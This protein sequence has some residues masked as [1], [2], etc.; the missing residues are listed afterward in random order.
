MALSGSV[1]TTAYDG[2]Y[3]QLD[4]TATQSIAANSSTIKW[5]LKA[6]TEG[7]WAERTLIVT[8]NG[9]DVYSKTA[10]VERWDGVVTSG[11]TTISH[12]SA[13]AANISISIKAAVYGSS[14]N[15]TGSSTVPLDTI[16]RKAELK[17][18]D[19]SWTDEENPKITYT[20]PAGTAVTSLQACI[21]WDK[22]TVVVAY[23]DIPKTGTLEYEFPLTPAEKTALQKGVNNG[24]TKRGVMFVIKTVIGSNEPEYSYNEASKSTLTI[25]DCAPT[26][27]PS[28]RDMN[29][30]TLKLTEGDKGDD[31]SSY[32]GQT[33][34]KGHS[35]VSASTGA[36]VP[37][38]GTIK[39]QAIVC[40]SDEFYVGS[41]EITN[42]TS[43]SFS[44]TVSDSRGQTVTTPRLLGFIN[45][46]NLSCSQS[47]SISIDD[48]AGETSAMANLTISGSYFDESFGAESNTLTLWYRYKKT[49]DPEWSTMEL[50][51]WRQVD[52]V[53][54]KSNGT[55]A[56]TIS[57]AGLSQT[58][59]YTF[60]CMA[61]DKLNNGADGAILTKEYKV[62]TQ[63]V[64]DWSETDFAFNV[65]VSFNGGISPTYFYE[66]HVNRPEGL[67][68]NDITTSG[69]YVCSQSAVA[70]KIENAP[71]NTAF[72]LEVLVNA[73]VTQRVTEYCESIPMKIFVRNY[74]GYI[75]SWGEWY[76][77]GHLSNGLG[78]SSVQLLTSTYVNDNGTTKSVDYT[79]PS[80]GYLYL[81]AEYTAGRYVNAVIKG[82]SGTSFPVTVT[83]GSASNMVANPQMSIYVR[84]G[85]KV[86]DISTS[87]TRTGNDLRFYPLT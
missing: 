55:Y 57:I 59:Q 61:E 10:R 11:T 27:N 87:A 56:V 2:R 48:E 73:G 58:E 50:D 8:I 29:L 43:G 64:F 84:K 85:M 12:N 7:W 75:S 23:R 41:K 21:A 15:C 69:F 32:T 25:T 62:K 40:G 86:G 76:E 63:P 45:Y 65:P 28:V 60:Q 30:K 81:K 9:T 51:G 4:W 68:L 70:A 17:T 33:I 26:L 44:F 24:S 38:N 52:D 49:T 39:T 34:V 19:V 80:D 36:S 72:A 5:T 6:M 42:P 77:C 3:Y 37:K 66:Y 54:S 18:Y 67:D 14:V 1:K 71:T 74:Y 82:R 53:I 20:N 79:F 46:I 35:V 13:G 83:S 22:S 16:P 78:P 31:I 47:V